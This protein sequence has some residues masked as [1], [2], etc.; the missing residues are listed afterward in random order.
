MPT[1][2]HLPPLNALRAFDMAGRHLNFRLAAEALSVTQGAVAQQ[3]RGLEA[4]LGMRLFDR[5]PRGLAFTEAGRAYH[6]QIT[7][8]FETLEAATRAL[9]PSAQQVT[10]SV[11]PSF[12]SRWLIPHLPE[13]TTRY[14]GIDLRILATERVSS[15]HSDGIDLAVRQGRPPFGASLRQLRL[16]RQ[17]IIAVCAPDLLESHTH[18]EGNPLDGLVLL[19]DTHNLWPEFLGGKAGLAGSRRDHGLQFNQTSL[20]IE[21]ALAGQGVALA[22][23]FLVQRDLDAGRLVQPVDRAL[24]GQQDFYL[25][26]A[27]KSRDQRAA[28]KAWD[29]LS[30]YAS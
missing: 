5:L 7:G 9:K 8:A 28:A 11:T 13:F 20:S 30:G 6:A 12:A 18:G 10:I 16:F 17:D 25:L 1:S 15:F 23:R 27:R 26:M 24:E 22:S 2:D 21:A 19:H 14:P 3:V 29:W 4:D